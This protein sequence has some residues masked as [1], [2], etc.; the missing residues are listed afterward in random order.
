M[1]DNTRLMEKGPHIALPI[2]DQLPY[3]TGQNDYVWTFERF[4]SVKN[5]NCE[6]VI[7]AVK[8]NF[9]REKVM[10]KLMKT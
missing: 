4:F 5:V 7:L 10:E 6:T 3:W 2:P 8:K 9:V 1:K